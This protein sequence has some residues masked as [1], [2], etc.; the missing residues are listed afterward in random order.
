[1]ALYRPIRVV[2]RWRH[3]PMQ[4]RLRS[5]SGQIAVIVALVIVVLLACGAL[6]T[7]IGFLQ[8][9][10]RKMQS[11][12]DSAAGAGVH[13]VLAGQSGSVTSAAQHDAVLNG[14]LR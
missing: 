12:A 1:M 9:S 3:C 2:I 5:N 13:E 6:A 11:A 7:D 4:T 14:L 8:N 10:R